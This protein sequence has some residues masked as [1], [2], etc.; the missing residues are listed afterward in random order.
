MIVAPSFLNSVVVKELL[1]ADLALEKE[2]RRVGLGGGNARRQSSRCTAKRSRKNFDDCVTLDIF[3]E[4]IIELDG[5]SLFHTI[6]CL[7]DADFYMLLADR[8]KDPNFGNIAVAIHEFKKIIHEADRL[9]Y[10][11]DDDGLY[12]ILTRDLFMVVLSAQESV[13]SFLMKTT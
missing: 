2:G 3:K 1:L 4:V 7:V 9:L 6:K 11:G 8:Q 12:Q 13:F 10:H 5:A